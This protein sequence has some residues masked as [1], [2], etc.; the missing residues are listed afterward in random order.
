MRC[1]GGG[2]PESQVMLRNDLDRE[3]KTGRG[4]GNVWEWDGHGRN[5]AQEGNLASNTPWLFRLYL[6]FRDVE[7]GWYF[8]SNI[9]VN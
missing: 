3:Q 4:L 2:G 9:Y 8:P 5:G 1:G 7:V 6:I